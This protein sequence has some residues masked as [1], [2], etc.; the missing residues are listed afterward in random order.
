MPTLLSSGQKEGTIT[1][2]AIQIP[3]GWV[4]RRYVLSA[5]VPANQ[6]ILGR[7]FWVR[8]QIADAEAG[9]FEHLA[10]FHWKGGFFGKDG[11]WDPASTRGVKP[12]HIGKWVRVVVEV[13]VR[14]RF[15]VDIDRVE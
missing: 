2:G 5:T 10:A 7:S 13:P 15:A 12:E 14:I 6:N 11:T 4:G 9:P 1:S 3:A 8:A